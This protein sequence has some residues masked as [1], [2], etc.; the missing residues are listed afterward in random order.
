[1]RN[2]LVIIFSIGILT[3]GSA[4][5]LNCTITV[6]SDQVGQT[7]QQIFR[8]LERSLTDFV[9]KTKWTNRVYK[10]N[11]RLN[12]RMFITVTNFDSNRFEA[13]IQ[14]QSSRPVI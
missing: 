6:N 9:N 2:L 1:M 12:C 3:G 10:E 5:E 4:Q 14:I 11:E 8:T 13:N 7:N